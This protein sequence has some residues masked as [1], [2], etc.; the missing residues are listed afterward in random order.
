MKH[1]EDRKELN[2]D[3]SI[4]INDVSKWYDKKK[5]QALDNISLKVNSGELFGLIGPDGAGKTSLIRILTT[6]LF[7][8]EGTAQVEQWDVE[9]D[10][11]KIRANVGYMR[12]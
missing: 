1:A 7:A 6:L 3:A 2:G 4:I 8:D 11:R 9:K 5:V 12:G 10:Y